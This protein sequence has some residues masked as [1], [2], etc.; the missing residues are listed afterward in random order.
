VLH[1]PRRA[2]AWLCTVL[3]PAMARLIDWQ[4]LQPGGGEVRSRDAAARRGR[5]AVPGAHAG[6]PRDLDPD[7]AQVGGDADHRPA[8]PLR[9][10]SAPAA[11]VRRRGER[12]LL[13]APLD[14]ATKLLL[15]CLGC[16]DGKHPEQV[17]AA[18]YRWRGLL[19]AVDQ[20]PRGRTVLRG[21]QWYCVSCAEADAAVVRDLIATLLNWTDDSLM[22]TVDRIR[23][24]SYKLGSLDGEVCGEVRGEA[25]GE[26]RGIH[27][28]R[29]ATLL[30]LIRRRFGEPAPDHV[31]RLEAATATDLNRYIDR[32]LDV[33]T[34]A[35]LFA[36]D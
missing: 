3:S 16:L 19:R 24:D 15:L 25:R 1:D 26:A 33:P 18:L 28:G 36:L 8:R 20:S 17:V 14:A 27:R 32:I 12:K 7:R 34:L 23:R 2:A 35:A 29:V 4:S 31:A 6:W 10:R 30:D 9:V 21:I 11:A 13:A 22:S 5:P